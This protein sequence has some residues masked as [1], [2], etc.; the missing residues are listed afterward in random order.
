MTDVN[1]L[2]NK[3]VEAQGELSNKVSSSYSDRRAEANELL[4]KLTPGVKS[5]LQTMINLANEFDL[6][7]EIADLENTDYDNTIYHDGSVDW[8]SSSA[9]C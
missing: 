1:D 2:V 3:I 6:V 4:K 9:Q 7:F 8:N 5:Q